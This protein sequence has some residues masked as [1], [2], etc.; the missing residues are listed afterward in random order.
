MNKY[1]CHLQ[2]AKSNLEKWFKNRLQAS[3]NKI[4]AHAAEIDGAVRVAAQAGGIDGIDVLGDFSLWF[5]TELG[6][7]NEAIQSAAYITSMV[8][9][10]VAQDILNVGSTA[11]EVGSKAVDVGS[12]VLKID[13]TAL[14]L[15][16]IKD[17]VDR[18]EKKVDKLLKEPLETAQSFFNHALTEM[19]H[20]CFEEAFETLQKVI[21]NAI[22][23]L[24]LV[25]GK[26]ISIESFG[27]HIKAA[28]LIAFSTILRHS[29]DKREK[30]F[31]PKFLLSSKAQMVIGDKLEAV[32]KD[33]R[34]QKENVNVKTLFIEIEGKKSAVQNM[35][36]SL[37]K[38]TYPYISQAKKWTDMKTDLSMSDGKM[39]ITL[40]PKYLPH[41]IEDKTELDIGFKIEKNILNLTKVN[42]WRMNK[43][44]FYE[45]NDAVFYKTIK[46]ESA[47]V[48][49]EDAE[50]V[51]VT[52]TFSATGPA[53]EKWDSR[54][55]GD[56]TLTEELR[57]GRPVYRNSEGSPLYTMESGAWGVS[58]SVSDSHPLYRS[59]AP[60]PSP[61]LC[62][63]WQYWDGGYKPGDIT[64]TVKK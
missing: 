38:V 19:I 16:Q 2:E 5:G 54:Y 25:K 63:N 20:E 52:V 47:P 37:L 36:D 12:A 62:Q 7:G 55:R 32:V 24:N 31:T 21:D 45:H 39:K 58:L 42:V 13:M 27:E 49:M 1:S 44:V 61:V 4:S 64:I 53:R 60:A 48:D 30:M 11:V 15:H 8:V 46:S 14:T 34:E 23:G 40:I 28:R 22:K 18:I 35:L 29:Y 10:D 43:I 3:A 51:H 57:Y 59:T 9:L 33:C 50:S 6:Q 41:G 17:T 26:N 56:F